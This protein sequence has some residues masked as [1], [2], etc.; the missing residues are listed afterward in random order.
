MMIRVPGKVFIAGEYG[1][2]KGFPTLSVAVNP[3]FEF[4]SGSGELRFHPQSPAGLLEGPLSYEGSLYDPYMST[5]GL[6]LSTAEFIVKYVKSHP[7]HKFSNQDAVKI[8]NE[9][10]RLHGSHKTPPSGVDLVTQVMGGYCV[11]EWSKDRFAQTQWGFA[12]LDWAVL[13]TGHKVKTH[14]HLASLQSLD[15]NKTQALNEKIVQAF[16]SQNEDAFVDSLIEWRQFLLDS[17]LEVGTTTEIVEALLD[18]HGVVAAKGCGALGSDAIFI[19]FE[20]SETSF[21]NRVLETWNP[22]QLIRSAQVSYSGL[23]VN[24]ED[25]Q[26]RS[27]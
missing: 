2:L 24:Y 23:E 19:L 22:K 14:D 27:L 5:G 13:L 18:S 9:Y 12:N 1:A 6:G 20:K 25:L 3:A 4:N 11:T 15:W 10:R 7:A 21:V 16:E 17:N 8:W 26:F